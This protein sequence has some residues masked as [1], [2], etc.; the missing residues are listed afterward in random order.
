MIKKT[1]PQAFF[2]SQEF[3][4]FCQSGNTGIGRRKRTRIRIPHLFAHIVHFVPVILG[5]NERAGL[6][7]QDGVY[8]GG[9]V[10]E[11]GVAEHFDASVDDAFGFS[12]ARTDSG[13]SSGDAGIA[14]QSGAQ[15]FEQ[16]LE[17]RFPIAVVFGK[18]DLSVDAVDDEVDDVLSSADVVVDD[19]RMRFDRFGQL[20]DGPAVD[21][22][23]FGQHKGGVA[24]G[25]RIDC[26]RSVVR[27]VAPMFGAF[28]FEDYDRIPCLRNALKVF[29]LRSSMR[30]AI[31]N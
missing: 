19:A 7:E 5:S 6:A 22:G 12:E 18:V 25:T 11:S 4:R 23:C 15:S 31:D 14:P 16:R 9:L 28:L 1:S 29:T 8:K 2:F 3:D 20:A 21:A 17:P 26:R 27:R 24:D 10:A 13:E 30:V